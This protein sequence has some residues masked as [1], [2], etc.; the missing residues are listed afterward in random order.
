[1]KDKCEH[2]VTH[3]FLNRRSKKIGLPP[4]A[5]VHIGEKKVEK[6]EIELYDFDPEGY[7]TKS[8]QKINEILPLR[9]SKSVSWINIVGLHDVDSINEICT[10][11]NIHSLVIEDIVNTDHRPKVE[12]TDDYIFIAAKMIYLDKKDD[13]IIIEHISIIL[14]ENYV[15]TFQERKEDIFES[16]RQRIRNEKSRLRKSGA[17]YLAYTLLDVLIDTYFLVLEKLNDRIEVVENDLVNN[18]DRAFVSEI[19]YLKREM[20]FLRKSTWPL[21]EILSTLTRDENPFFLVST[22]PFLRDLYDHIIQ[23]IDT[24]ETMR[25]MVSGLLDIYLSSI[26]NKTNE[27]MRVLTII[28]TIFIPLTFIAGIYGMN[29]EFMPELKWHYAYPVFWGIILILFLGML[30]YFKRKKWI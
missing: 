14:G 10:P 27:V 4:G 25:D 15:L 7:S 26:S 5:P 8:V 1:L 13:K 11:F 28:A 17:D 2:R 3:K 6:V 18:P 16:I 22:M 12:I 30:L 19:Q 23:I 24:V 9:D 29:F 20:I 21:R